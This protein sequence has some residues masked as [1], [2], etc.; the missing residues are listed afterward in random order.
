VNAN[1]QNIFAGCSKAANP[2]QLLDGDPWK[3]ILKSWQRLPAEVTAF[4]HATGGERHLTAFSLL[5]AIYDFVQVL[6]VIL[7]EGTPPL[8]DA[9]VVRFNR[10]LRDW[11]RENVISD[12]NPQQKDMAAADS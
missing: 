5:F 2:I 9:N 4:D 11:S 12:C 6:S 8:D 7:D 10:L 3:R 1:F